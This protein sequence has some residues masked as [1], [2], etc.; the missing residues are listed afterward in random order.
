MEIQWEI[1]RL[2]LFSFQLEITHCQPK[3][4]ER[5]TDLFILQEP[6]SPIDIGNR[7]RKT[8]EKSFVKKIHVLFNLVF[9]L[10]HTNHLYKFC[11]TENQNQLS[12]KQACRS[13]VFMSSQYSV[14][15]AFLS[16]HNVF[17]ICLGKDR[18][19]LTV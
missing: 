16:D 6:W 5:G 10:Y 7:A 14:C 19:R 4:R 18:S 11:T 8:I 9:I 1:S 12:F 17:N 2:W 3:N 15:F 13:H